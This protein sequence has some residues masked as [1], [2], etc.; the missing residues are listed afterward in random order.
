MRTH[1]YGSHRLAAAGPASARQPRAAGGREARRCDRSGL[2]PVRCRGAGVSAGRRVAL[3]VASLVACARTRIC[4]RAARGCRCC[5]DRRSNVCARSCRS[6]RRTRSV[7]ESALR[8][9][10]GRARYRS[11]DAAA[12]PTVS[13]PKASTARC[14]ASRGRFRTALAI[15][16][17][18]SRH[19]SVAQWRSWI[20]PHRCA[21]PRAGRAAKMAGLARR[22]MTCSCC[23]TSS[24]TRRWSR[25]GVPAK[26]ARMRACAHSRRSRSPSYAK[27]RDRP[28]QDGTSALSPHLHFGEISVRQVWHALAATNAQG[29]ASRRSYPS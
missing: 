22:S 9:C 20:R 17:A 4:A 7:L 15:R 12:R 25:R 21:C 26:P 2:H 24:G 18:S 5:A 10:R 29:C 16:I 11:E 3:V 8:A 1:E 13:S 19:S 27:M 6:Y 28:D 23:R 14:C